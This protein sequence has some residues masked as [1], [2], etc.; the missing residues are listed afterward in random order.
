M[1]RQAGPFYFVGAIDD[2]VFYKQGDNYYVRQKGK[3]TAGV[4]KRLK[5]PACYPLMHLRQKEFGR[6]SK[7]AS[8]VYRTLPQEK[9]GHGVQGRL[10]KIVRGLLREGKSEAEVMTLLRPLYLGEPVAEK[11]TQPATAVAPLAKPQAEKRVVPAVKKQP[12]GTA[13]SKWQV[14]AAREW[15]KERSEVTAMNNRSVKAKLYPVVPPWLFSSSPNRNTLCQNSCSSV[16]L[17]LGRYARHR[18]RQT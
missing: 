13:L 5:D 4:K 15:P 10:T 11:P 9:R 18:C 17:P 6:A 14:L 2:L 1:A 16:P 7:L 8:A 3:P 12:T